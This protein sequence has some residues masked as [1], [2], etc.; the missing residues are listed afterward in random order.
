[1]ANALVMQ[2]C[3][4][5]PKIT[6]SVNASLPHCLFCTK[7][8]CLIPSLGEPRCKMATPEKIACASHISF[9]L[10]ALS[11]QCSC[12]NINV[13]MFDLFCMGLICTLKTRAL[14][15]M[16]S[17]I[18]SKHHDKIHKA[19]LHCS[20]YSILSSCSWVPCQIIIIVFETDCI[21][22]K[23]GWS[24]KT[25][26]TAVAHEGCNDLTCTSYHNSLVEA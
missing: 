5:L 6:P 12:L 2:R 18:I 10:Q 11:D 22:P 14:E 23:S 9:F 4:L 16:L 20:I 21:E 15:Y 19:T 3:P 1:M 8:H 24:R 26:E 13:E 7:L 25:S 17:K